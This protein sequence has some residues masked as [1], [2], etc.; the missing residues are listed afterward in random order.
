MR[1]VKESGVLVKAIGCLIGLVG[2][3]LRFSEGSTHGR[4]VGQAAC[5]KRADKMGWMSCTVLGDV[6]LFLFFVL[7]LEVQERITTSVLTSLA[8]RLGGAALIGTR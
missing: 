5:N 1:D 8:Q 3:M 7:V 4:Y 2:C 6:S